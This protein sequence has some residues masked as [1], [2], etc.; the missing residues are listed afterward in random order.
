MM[1]NQ[2]TY[3]EW[4]TRQPSSFQKRV[5]SPSQYET[6]KKTGEAPES[7]KDEGFKPIDLDELKELDE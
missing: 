2:E 5:L 7:F 1:D 4:M 3:A 6:L